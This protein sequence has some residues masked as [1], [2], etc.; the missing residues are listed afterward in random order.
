MAG[1]RE[2]FLREENLC[3]LSA[4]FNAM[5]KVI[6]MYSLLSARFPPIMTKMLE[7]HITAIITTTNQIV[8]MMVRKQ[9]S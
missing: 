4:V 1:V 8:K 9:F 7:L 2:K 3:L 5:D 6:T